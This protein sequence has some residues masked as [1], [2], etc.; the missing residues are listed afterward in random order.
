MKSLNVTSLRTRLFLLVILATVPGLG[1]IVFSGFEQKVDAIASSH[2]QCLTLIKTLSQDMEDTVSATRQMLTTLSMLPEV[3]RGDKKTCGDLFKEIVKNDPRYL[4]V[5]LFTLEGISL[6]A[7]MPPPPNLD[8]S[9]RKYFREALAR[10]AFAAG[11]FIIGRTVR[12]P[13]FNFALPVRNE[14]GDIVAVIQAAIALGRI[15]DLYDTALAPPGATLTL[16]DHK[17][18]ILFHTDESDRLIGSQDDAQLFNDMAAS[19]RSA[20]VYSRDVN[21][22][23][24][25]VAFNSLGLSGDAKPYMYLRLE[26]PEEAVLSRAHRI[27]V[28]NLWLMAIVACISGV[29]AFLFSRYGILNRPSNS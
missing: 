15:K 27:L 10:K 26:V 9:D 16:L 4:N 29:A 19:P 8:V 18:T 23:T 13:T 17:G 1:I 25:I 7:A 20:K 5:Q 14:Q 21:G 12:R 28:R 24:R 2:A 11:E 3:R 22:L 6:A